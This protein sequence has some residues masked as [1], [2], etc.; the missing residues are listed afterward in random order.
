MRRIL[1]LIVTLTA[2]CATPALA[3]EGFPTTLAGFTL[4]ESVERYEDYCHMERAIPVSD[5]PFLSEVLLKPGALPGVRGGSLAFGN[6]KS[7][8]RLVRIKLKFYERGQDFFSRLN[9]RYEAVFGKPD[10]YLG[11][12]F[13]NVIAWEWLFTNGKGQRVSLVL[14]WSRDKEMRPGVS[15]K[16][17]QETD[18]DEEYACFKT[19]HEEPMEKMGMSKVRSLDAY[20]PH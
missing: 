8:G 10:K 4:G 16:M 17:T 15:I 9:D 5:A 6:C 3:G 1:L 11:D 13:K 14:M 19:E 2:L 20:V 7:E 18:M 12:A